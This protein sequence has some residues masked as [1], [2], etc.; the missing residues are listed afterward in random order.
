MSGRA[1]RAVLGAVPTGVGPSA[2]GIQ[3]ESLAS[4]ENL[5]LGAGERVVQRTV[6]MLLRVLS[7]NFS[8]KVPK[9]L[10]F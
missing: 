4:R 2:Q 7:Q 9:P 1:V 10:A 3:I 5:L 8:L 6:H